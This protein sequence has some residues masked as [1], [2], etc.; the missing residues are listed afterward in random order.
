MNVCVKRVCYYYKDSAV[1]KCT[2]DENGSKHRC[3]P[4]ICFNLNHCKPNQ[5]RSFCAVN[6]I[7]NGLPIVEQ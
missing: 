1:T 4:N 7:V 5:L 6:H 3:E 2:T